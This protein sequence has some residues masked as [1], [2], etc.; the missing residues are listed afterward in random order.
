MSCSS[1]YDKS[2]QT[3]QHVSSCSSGVGHGLTWVSLKSRCRRGGWRLQ[4]RICP[5]PSPAPWSV[6]PSS[7][8]KAAVW[9]LPRSLAL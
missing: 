5:P 2:T 4:G 1:C 9:H 7:T 8:L 6:A 3:S